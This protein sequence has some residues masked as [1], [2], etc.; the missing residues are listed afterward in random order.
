MY[1][2]SYI[3]LEKNGP[4]QQLVLRTVNIGNFKILSKF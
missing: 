1:S 2:L 4:L 3:F